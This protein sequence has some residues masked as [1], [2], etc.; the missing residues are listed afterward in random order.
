MSRADTYTRAYR[1]PGIPCPVC[2][3][4]LILRPAQGRKSGKPFL[5]LVCPSDGR[6]FRTFINDQ[7]YVRQVFNRLEENDGRG[8]HSGKSGQQQ[9]DLT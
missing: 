3:T 4:T 7:E 2:G 6:H 9:R 5:M 1:E 8:S